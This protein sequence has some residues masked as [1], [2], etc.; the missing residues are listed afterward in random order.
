MH[1]ENCY[2]SKLD[3]SEVSSVQSTVNNVSILEEDL[4][5][6]SSTLGTS[7]KCEDSFEE[8]EYV[9]YKSSNRVVYLNEDTMDC[10]YS[11]S[12]GTPR[13]HPRVTDP[14]S[15][16]LFNTDSETDSPRPKSST[17]T[18]ILSQPSV[19]ISPRKPSLSE[20]ILRSDE[21]LFRKISKSL[22]GVPPPPSHTISQSDCTDFLHCI[23]QNREYFWANPFKDEKNLET[24]PESVKS[25][26]KNEG[27]ST[28]IRRPGG[29]RNLT[30]A[31]DACDAS[32]SS[33]S[34]TRTSDTNTTTD[35]FETSA[36]S[37]TDLSRDFSRDV[38]TC[39][40]SLEGSETTSIASESN[41]PVVRDVSTKR[42]TFDVP[43]ED[44]LAIF[45]TIEESHARA[46]P[47]P[48][49]Y[50][51]KSQGIHYNR[52]RF[53]EDFENLA[54][55]LCQRYVGN[56]TQSTCTSWFTKQAPSSVKK[57]TLLGRRNIGQSPG[58]RL[59]HL[60]RR[61]RTFSS[62]NLQ[63]MAEK[64]QLMLNLK[65][66]GLKKG[67]SPRGKSPR[68]KS[69]RGS[70]KKKLARK[71]MMEGPSPRKVKLET[72]KRA[73]FQSPPNDRAG[74]SFVSN[75]QSSNPQR[76]KRAL[77]PTPKK[78]DELATGGDDRKGEESKKRK[79]DEDLEGPKNK[80]ARNLSFDCSH[81]ENSRDSQISEMSDIN[82]RKLLFAVSDALRSKGVTVGHPKFKQYAGQLAKIVKKYMP[83]LENRN[84]PKKTG[85][86]TDRML[87]LAKTYVPLVIESTASS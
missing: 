53:I 10:N 32:S 52:N 60:A 22:T 47:W 75:N 69:P 31:F 45:K 7:K 33:I 58:K 55:R 63:G 14:T 25:P 19:T 8:P 38:Q 30:N 27:K 43:E 80:W 13:I 62:A 12:S 84:I 23:K 57:R 76:I 81:V 20:Q 17:F 1:T 4:A 9:P 41:L 24:A 86:T 72:S 6:S 54:M 61:R 74:P 15:P 51:H 11:E 73:L 66:P 16:D 3:T 87:K 68:G 34:I 49:I 48:V 83:D 36:H 77:F 46:L 2:S 29:L 70:A 21:Y 28:I 26:P 35:F 78:K 85:S 39:Q 79:S 42:V 18:R 40:K 65:K 67:K 44:H 64:R 5:L 50:Q 37:T 56:E 82:R 71:L 59:S